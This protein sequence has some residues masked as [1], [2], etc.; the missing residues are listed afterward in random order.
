MTKAVEN[1]DKMTFEAALSELETIVRN[2]ES[3][4]TSLDDSIKAYER[5]MELKKL[6]ETRLADARLRVEKISL[7]ADGKPTGTTPFN[8][9][10]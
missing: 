1:V 9:D 4:Q 2:L 5:G 10:A 6:C 8:P 7:S 3:G